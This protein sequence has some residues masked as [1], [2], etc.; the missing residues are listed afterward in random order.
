MTAMYFT[1]CLVLPGNTVPDTRPTSDSTVDVAPDAP[2]GR[3]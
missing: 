2:R 3:M 1:V